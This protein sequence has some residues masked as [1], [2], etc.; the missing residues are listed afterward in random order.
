M[1]PNFCMPAR[2]ACPGRG[3]VSGA[4]LACPASTASST[5]SADMTVSHLGHSVL[6][7]LIAIGPPSVMPCRTPAV[8]STSSCSNV[9]R[10][11]RP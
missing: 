11:P 1:W 2:S 8:S 7:I 5:G 6:A 10:A 3:L 4:F 9:I